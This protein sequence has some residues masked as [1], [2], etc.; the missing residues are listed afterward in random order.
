MGPKTHYTVL[1]VGPGEPI[2]GIRSAY[3]RLAK[4]LHPDHSGETSG[5]AFR[6]LQS[7]YDV[8]SDPERRRRY[9]RQL[10]RSQWSGRRWPDAAGQ[11]RCEPL[12]SVPEPVGADPWQPRP[13]GGHWH[14]VGRPGDPTPIGDPPRTEVVELVAAI[15][16]RQAARGGVFGVRLPVRHH[17]RGCG[18]SGRDRGWP[19]LACHGAG[20]VRSEQLL[21]LEVPPDV[22]TGDILEVPGPAVG[23]GGVT[24]RVRLILES[25]FPY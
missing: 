11:G 14:P 22:R 5:A 9:D 10:G 17:C 18:G 2:E 13:P 16:P 12:T 7:A 21:W 3:L 24:L 23:P 19:C 25:A 8:L 6:E 1:G 20:S 4:A 15:S